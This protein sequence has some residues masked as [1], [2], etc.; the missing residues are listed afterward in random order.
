MSQ[1]TEWWCVLVAFVLLNLAYASNQ[2]LTRTNDGFGHD[3]RVYHAMAKGFPRQM[4]PSAPAP[5]VYRPG[6]PFMVAAVAKSQDWVLSAGFDRINIVLNVFSVVGLIILLRRHVS[7]APARLVAVFAFMI[8]PHSPIRHAYFS[9]MDL[10]PVTMAG[11]IAGLCLVGWYQARP[12]FARMSAVAVIV[13]LGVFFHEAILLIGV[14]TLGCAAPENTS[15][16]WRWLPLTSGTVGL[17]AVRLWAVETP[18]GFSGYEEL[19]R[20]LDQKS[21]LQY[22]LAWLLVFGPLLAVPLFYWRRSARFLVDHPVLLLCLSVSA[23]LAWS[24]GGEAE[25]W[26]VLA[27]PVV[28]LLIALGVMWA[29]LELTLG[30]LAGIVLLQALSSRIFAQIG[31]PIDPPEVG[32]EVWE[33]LGWAGAKWALSDDNMWSLT[34]AP[35]MTY[36][37]A[38][39]Y[40]LIG[41]GII[42]FLRAHAI[43][44]P[45]Q[46]PDEQAVLNS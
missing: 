17:L 41:V 21:L 24:V 8:E 29:R 1:R 37:Y 38:I 35:L 12:S 3:G 33:R 31:G 16:D 46:S 27:S 6:M 45:T 28:Y 26:L 43:T 36:V 25:R 10:A 14:C 42:A 5:Y 11:L 15:D 7:S 32:S 20:G 22:G 19:L 13:G 40:G 23:L 18:S 34:S 44:G 2:S 9:P 4:P 30:A 39:W